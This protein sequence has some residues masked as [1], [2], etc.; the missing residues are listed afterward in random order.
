MCNKTALAFSIAIIGL[1]ITGAIVS[2]FLKDEDDQ[3]KKSDNINN[4][5]N[6][7]NMNGNRNG[8]FARLNSAIAN[9]NLT[10]GLTYSPSYKSYISSSSMSD[11]DMWSYGLYRGGNDNMI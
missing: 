4:Y 8:N 10:R 7:M 3:T 6:T 2:L 1:L 5:K 11:N 9:N